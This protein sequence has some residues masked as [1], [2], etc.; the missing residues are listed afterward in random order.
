MTRNQARK[1]N[2][3]IYEEPKY[4]DLSDSNEKKT[5]KATT[6]LLKRKKNEKLSKIKLYQCLYLEEKE[7]DQERIH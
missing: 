3:K 2:A 1:Q 4:K 7:A 6:N 5:K